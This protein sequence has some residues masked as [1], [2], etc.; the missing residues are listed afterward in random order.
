M[1]CCAWKSA[2]SLDGREQVQTE[3]KLTEELP[4]E[5]M[6]RL[7]Q[8]RLQVRAVVDSLASERLA[9][10]LK[11]TDEQKKQLAEIN[12]QLQAK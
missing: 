3:R 1:P 2:R 12:E 4:R 10:R 9:S 7:D 8:I 6:I 11:I 5:Q